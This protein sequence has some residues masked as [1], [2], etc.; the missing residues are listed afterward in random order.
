MELQTPPE[1]V[2]KWRRDPFLIYLFSFTNLWCS[3]VSWSLLA[4]RASWLEQRRHR[5]Q[6]GAV[7]AIPPDVLQKNLLLSKSKLNIDLYPEAWR[8]I[9]S[10]I[11]IAEGWVLFWVDFCLNL[12]CSNSSCIFNYWHR[13]R[14]WILALSNTPWQGALWINKGETIPC[15]LWKAMLKLHS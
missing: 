14:H 2:G 12:S 3:D 15:F 9:P 1:T 5:I 10:N 13:L 6:G 7:T 8:H 4:G 11:L